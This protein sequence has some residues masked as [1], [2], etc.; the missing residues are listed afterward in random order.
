VENK[1]SYDISEIEK[2][3]KM[4]G[5][6]RSVLDQKILS[7][8]DE[9]ISNAIEDELKDFIK[10]RL[11]VLLG[12]RATPEAAAHF[13]TTEVLVLKSFAKKVL[14]SKDE[15]EDAPDQEQEEEVV[16]KPPKRAAQPKPQP[17]PKAAPK[18]KPTKTAPKQEALPPQEVP[19]M[20]EREIKTSIEFAEIGDIVEENG[21]RYEIIE[22]NGKM[23]P[24]DITKQAVS[25]DRLPMP[26]LQA[27]LQQLA[28]NSLAAASD[29]M[30]Q[31]LIQAALGG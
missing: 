2:R 27:G 25:P 8:T 14:S 18:P 1:M 23:F 11:E 3:L 10:G 29:P 26:P 30:T 12:V 28:Y 22:L 4:A 5:A 9:Q 13:T 20:D 16:V 7:G 19:D 6:Y 21:R 17:K 15:P 24:K 31:T